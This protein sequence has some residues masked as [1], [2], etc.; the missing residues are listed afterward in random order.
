VAE[1]FVFVVEPEVS[2]DNNAVELSRRHLVS[3]GSAADGEV[4]GD[5]AGARCR[6]E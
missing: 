6:R 1:L 2:P 3:E 5:A 4:M